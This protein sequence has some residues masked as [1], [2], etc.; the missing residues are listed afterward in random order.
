MLFN[1][2][3]AKLPS[4]FLNLLLNS[5]LVCISESQDVPCWGAETNS[6]VRLF[7][8]F[9]NPTPIQT[10]ATVID[11]AVIYQCFYRN[12]HTDPYNC[13]NWEVTSVRVRFFLNF[14]LR[15]R[16]KKAESCRSQESDSTPA[17]RIRSRVC[18]IPGV[19]TEPESAFFSD[20]PGV[21]NLLKPDLESLVAFNSSQSLHGLINVIAFFFIYIIFLFVNV[22]A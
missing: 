21:K 11:P 13:P 6:I 12:A 1:D 5:S 18:H 17:L 22:I 16:K 4:C 7:F 15:V 20:E 3:S 9:G 10:P 2:I 19:A 14:L 8:K